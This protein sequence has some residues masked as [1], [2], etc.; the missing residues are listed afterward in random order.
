MRQE[1]IAPF[2]PGIGEGSN[3]SSLFRLGA[4]LFE[5]R[6][7]RSLSATTRHVELPTSLFELRRDKTPRQGKELRRHPRSS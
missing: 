2:R 4:S 3:Q 1:L 6:T 5:L 7:L